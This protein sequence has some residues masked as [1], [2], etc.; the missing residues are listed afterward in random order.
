MYGPSPFKMPS[1]YSSYERELKAIMAGER[2]FLNRYRKLAASPERL[3]AL[4][5]LEDRPFLVIRAAGSHGFDL[6][7]LRDSI[8]LPIEVK[9]SGEPVIHFTA[10]RG[11]N[12]EQYA[13]L[14]KE[15]LR[16]GLILLYA[17]RLMG[18]RDGDPWRLFSASNGDTK[19]IARFIANRTPN[20]DSTEKGNQV[21]R[22]K[23]GMPLMDFLSM[24]LEFS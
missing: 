4:D 8:A 24:V 12:M 18:V 15:T 14:T 2:E 19:G 6:L 5:K 21:L 13:Q 16:S 1:G 23:D 22:W 11:R 7:A 10:S 17:Y 9:C 20:L 3:A